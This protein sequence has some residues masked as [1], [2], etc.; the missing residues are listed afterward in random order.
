VAVLFGLTVLLTSLVLLMRFLFRGM[1]LQ[2][3]A[4]PTETD[5]P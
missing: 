3:S 4:D 2:V 5:S 1:A